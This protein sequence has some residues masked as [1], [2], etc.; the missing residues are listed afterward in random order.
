M[1]QYWSWPFPATGPS[2]KRTMAVRLSDVINVKD[3][4][5]TGDNSTDD[6]AAIQAAI[7]SCITTVNGAALGATVFFPPG[8]YKIGGPLTA[9]SNND[10]GIR[11]LG[12]GR[13][14]SQITTRGGYSDPN[15]YGY[16]LSRG[17][18]TYDNIERVESLGGLSIKLTRTCASV[19]GCTCAVDASSAQNVLLMDCI[20]AGSTT[21]A[22]DV[23]PGGTGV[24]AYVG[25]CG[26]IVDCRAQWLDIGF[27][28]SGYGASLIGSS[29]EVDNTVV[30]VGWGPSGEAPAIGCVVQG[31]Q[32]ERS[33]VC[34]DLY[35]AQGCVVS[36][37][38]LTG[39]EGTPNPAAISSMTW[40]V[41][42]ANLVEVTT[43]QNHNISVSPVVIR[44]LV[45]SSWAP[46]N[47]GPGTFVVAT[48]TAANKFTYPGVVSNPGS[49]GST[50]QW[51]WPC[52]Y[53]IRCRK[54]K[55]S[56]IV[57]N[58]L[59]KYVA[60]A[61][62]DLDYDGQAVDHR[63]NVLM[64]HNAIY[65]YT[66]PTDSKQLAG[67]KFINNTGQVNSLAHVS[68][69]TVATPTGS[70]HFADLPGQS[71]VFQPGPFETQ[72]YD[73][74]DGAK[75]GGGSAAWNDQVQGGGSGH[76]KVRH[77]G[78]NWLRIG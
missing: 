50:P 75:S 59:A 63:N 8:S 28:L 74:I 49:Y 36:T 15:N 20:F 57:G 40:N 67:W 61:H 9:G 78:T 31:L 2:F 4:G 38:I 22:N 64:G 18:G 34:V 68:P 48:V 65:G 21:N 47:A 12:S 76:Y 27:A 6:R 45:P 25:N 17:A 26:S 77:D 13:S 43:T 46:A 7:D 56:L 29:G 41:A 73:I 35:N 30:R 69:P 10:V 1:P 23:N 54:V 70:M 60:N 58:T 51:N 39:T 19:V 53:C 62:V 11:F 71:G 52:R 44:L 66:V 42:G 24:G 37:G 5:A 72:E 14:S 33:F 16:M 55:D 32:T 3:W